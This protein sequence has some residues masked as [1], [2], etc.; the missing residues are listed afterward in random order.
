MFIVAP[1]DGGDGAAAAPADCMT[2]QPSKF[3]QFIFNCVFFFLQPPVAME[4]DKRY[5]LPTDGQSK[6]VFWHHHLDSSLRIG[7]TSGID[8]HFQYIFI[9]Y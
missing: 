6:Y 4:V 5:L 3:N 1:A 2:T 9:I 8:I 7:N